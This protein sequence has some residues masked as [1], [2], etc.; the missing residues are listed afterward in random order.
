MTKEKLLSF[1]RCCHTKYPA[2]AAIL[3]LLFFSSGASLCLTACGKTEENH[4]STDSTVQDTSLSEN[5]A[6]DAPF[7][8]SPEQDSVSLESSP[9]HSVPYFHDDSGRSIQVSDR[10]LYGYWNGKVCQYD[11]DTLG[12]SSSPVYREVGKCAC[13]TA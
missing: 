10:Y 4:T 8:S 13:R 12:F 5:P 2:M 3:F 9:F 11:L 1:R 6:S 7:Q